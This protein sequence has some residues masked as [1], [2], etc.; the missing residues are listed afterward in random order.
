MKKNLLVTTIAAV[1]LTAGAAFA[2]SSS[3]HAISKI[4]LVNV[5][6]LVQ[7]SP[8]VKQARQHLQSQMKQKQKDLKSEQQKVQQLA[9]KLH[10][11]KS[12][13]S[14]S[15]Q[16]KLQKKINSKRKDLIQKQQQFRQQAQKAR[17]QAMH[18]F[19]NSAQDAAKEVANKRGLDMVLA[20]NSVL[21]ANKSMDITDQV[22]AKVKNS[23]KS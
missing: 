23:S 15:D 11:N 16:K 2:S 14:K 6:K 4:G 19:L 7:N 18:Q 22:E 8:Q 3:D 1:S 13:M 10:R 5:Q 20:D 17:Q 12:T 9:K 21:Y